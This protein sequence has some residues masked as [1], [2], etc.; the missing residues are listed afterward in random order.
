MAFCRSLWCWSGIYS[1]SCR[2]SVCGFQ[3]YAAGTAN[4]FSPFTRKDA[5]PLDRK[6]F[7]GNAGKR[8]ARW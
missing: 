1:L 3:K 5:L 6:D 7:A 4:V 8:S 2:D